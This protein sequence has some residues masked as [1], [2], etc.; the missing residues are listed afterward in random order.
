M[1]LLLSLYF[2]TVFSILG[3]EI[4]TSLA[5]SGGD[6]VAMFNGYLIWY[7]AADFLIRCIMQP[8]PS[9]DVI[10][11]FRFRLRR[12]KIINHLLVR[13]AVNLFNFLP[14]FLIIPFVL[15]VLMPIDGTSAGLLYL[16]GCLLLLIFN[17]YF[18]LLVGFPARA[19]FLYYL[20]PLGIA[21]ALGL[22]NKYAI[23]L[24]T[25]SADL[26]R[27]LSE[28]NPFVFAG[29]AAMITAVIMLIRRILRRN[30]YI[31][32]T[33]SKRENRAAGASFSGYFRRLGD[34]GRYMSLEIIMLARN[35][36]PRNTMLLAPIFLIYFCFMFFQS[37]TLSGQTLP[38]VI[39]SLV[40]GLG[41]VSYGQLIFSWESTYFDGIMARKNNF[42]SY[43][44]AKVYLLAILAIIAFV[45]LAV[46]IK[47]TGK[48]N[49]F[50]FLAL[51]LFN[52]GA[53]AFIVMML[54]MLN[55]GRLDLK[56]GTFM[57]YQ[58]VKGSQFFL[59]LFFVALPVA[60]FSLFQ[61]LIND[62]AG[63]IVIA[64]IGLLFIFSHEWW[65]KNVIA[66]SFRAR[67][68]KSLEGFRKLST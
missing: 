60:L 64:V 10:P 26:G 12:S 1:Y 20:I 39:T 48:M 63:I 62:T 9:L 44:R 47:I 59:A 8:I 40:L 25:F 38:L 24:N 16:A 37:D 2:I 34:T 13:S 41:S 27:L 43:L 33:N 19:N 65:L 42:L 66:A 45:P 61:F 58:G 29:V 14:L 52:L 67:K 57:N 7:L 17:N 22:I 6:A 50:L 5:K 18:A 53:N 21:G 15:K 49:I 56:A 35:K 28:G 36:R 4:S 55:D 54:A 3:Y 30:L 68:Y 46:V 31:D 51:F 32:R 11:Y 23:P